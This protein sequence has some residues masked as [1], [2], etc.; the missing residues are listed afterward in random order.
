MNRGQILI[1]T[2]LLVW[3]VGLLTAQITG[4]DV[5]TICW[6]SALI[7]IGVWMLVRPR[8]TIFRE[9]FNLHPVGD[10]NR[11]GSWRV[12]DEEF[13]TFAGDVHLDLTRAEIPAGETVFRVSGFAGDVKLLAPRS[14]GVSVSA[15]GFV[16]EVKF[17]GYKKESFLTGI[18]QATPEYDRAEQ[19]VRLE[20]TFFAGEVEV[21]FI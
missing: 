1:G 3:G 4:F 13:W 17:P 12:R 19:K 14:V 10:F 2:L 16:S 21:D 11:Y 8:L 15:N 18:R 6:P 7:V 9:G 5:S 20:T